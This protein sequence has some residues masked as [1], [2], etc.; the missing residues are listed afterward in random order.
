MLKNTRQSFGLVSIILHWLMAVLLMVLFVMGLYM[1]SL[2][3]YDPLYHSL[4][5][6]HKSL[7]LLTVLLLVVRFIWKLWNI[8]PKPLETHKTWE[9]TFVHLLQL[10]FYVLIT[11]IGLAGYLV[12]T[13][14]GKGIEFFNSSEV[15]ALFDKI[16]EGRADLF[17]DVH[18][19]LAYILAVFVLLH[20]AAAL[21]HHFIDKDITL[22]RMLGITT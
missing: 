20:A 16:G 3:Y 9:I 5:W 12:S 17:G 6:W 4:P 18:E 13:S 19:V 14:K 7:G 2:D 21:K 11:L 1:T 10:A 15:P 8:E 22:K